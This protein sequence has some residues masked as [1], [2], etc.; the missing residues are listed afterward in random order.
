MVGC[1]ADKLCRAP[2]GQISTGFDAAE[3][4][5]SENFSFFNFATVQKKTS[6]DW[7]FSHS[8]FLTVVCPAQGKAWAREVN[9][10]ATLPVNK[11]GKRSTQRKVTP[12]LFLSRDGELHDIQEYKRSSL[13]MY[14]ICYLHLSR[15]SFFNF[16][17][18]PFFSIFFPTSVYL[19]NLASMQPRISPVKF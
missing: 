5:P 11:E 8:S 17:P 19:L 3:S 12:E 7:R 4:E 15:F 10:S 13:S 9:G 1:C 2:A 16:L 14:V 18:C 6:F